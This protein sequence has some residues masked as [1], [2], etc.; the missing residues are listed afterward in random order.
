[1]VANLYGDGVGVIQSQCDGVTSYTNLASA[2]TSRTDITIADFTK[3]DNISFNRVG[4]TIIK[5]P[6]GTDPS[7]IAKE[8]IYKGFRVFPG[9]CI[10]SGNGIQSGVII[11]KVIT[12]NVID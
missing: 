12:R 11:D 2:L 9:V 7:S 10:A 1:L 5:Y 4:A 8:Y 3:F 6:E